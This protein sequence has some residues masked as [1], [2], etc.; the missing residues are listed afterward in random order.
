MQFDRPFPH[1]GEGECAKSRSRIT[2]ALDD[3]E[4]LWIFAYGSLLWRPCYS[5]VE[6]RMAVA[7][8]FARRLCVW[9]LEARGTPQRPGLG[10]G[11]DRD[12][13]SGCSGVLHR[14]AL[15][16]REAALDALWA[17]EMLTGIYRPAWIRV[18]S[19]GAPVVALAFVVDRAHPQY[20][21][22]LCRGVQA[23]M[24][25]DARGSLGSCIEYV[26]NTLEA[27]ASAGIDEPELRLVLQLARSRTAGGR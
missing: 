13:A 14:I 16:D 19:S 22:A 27:L 11:L 23:K 18:T 8:G 26:A 12:P 1:L 25:A 24:V 5:L 9:T 7:E 20:A 4:A 17:R 3:K 15:T 6:Q 10:L 21:G 2:A